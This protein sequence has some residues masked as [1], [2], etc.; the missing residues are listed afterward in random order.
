MVRVFD[1]LKKENLKSKLILQIHDELI[2]EAPQDEAMR[3]AMILQEEME[4][5]V[6]L[7]VP[8]VAE[9]AVGKTWYDAKG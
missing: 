9:A 3:V 2:V 5:A 7:D 4:G 1:R 8:L 6:K